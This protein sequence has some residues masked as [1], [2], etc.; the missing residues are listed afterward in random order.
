MFSGLV[1]TLEQV[2]PSIDASFGCYS[3]DIYF[4]LNEPEHEALVRRVAHPKLLLAEPDAP[5]PEKHYRQCTHAGNVGVQSILRQFHGLMRVNE[6]R[7]S[8][9]IAYDWAVRIRTDLEII[10]SPEP[11][12]E[13]S[14]R[15]IYVPKFANWCGYND[16]FAIGPPELMDIYMER[17]PELETFV[18]D[19]GVFHAESFLAYH[20]RR[21]QVPVG[22]T[23]IL[24]NLLR[25][26]GKRDEPA[27]GGQWGDVR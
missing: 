11:F 12:E 18:A 8:S 9:G 13:L 16:R 27:W 5:Q 22:R 2:W 19:T 10:R 23:N 26:N 24:F 20:L 7:K 1:R 3:P 4:Y 21:H 15:I 14:E 6:L 17:Y 25:V